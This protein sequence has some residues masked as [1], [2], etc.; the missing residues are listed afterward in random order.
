MIMNL[1][2][3]VRKTGENISMFCQKVFGENVAQNVEGSGDVAIMEDAAK[4][5][6]SRKETAELVRV[7]RAGDKA[8]N[9]FSRKIEDSISLNR[10]NENVIGNHTSIQKT[11][12]TQH[13]IPQR[14]N[15]DSKDKDRERTD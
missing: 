14:G 15:K 10:E 4:D 2:D 5:H 7:S 11:V 3:F 1:R 12:H 6:L 9:D 13:D 8:G